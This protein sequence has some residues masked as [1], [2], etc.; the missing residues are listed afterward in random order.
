MKLNRQVEGIGPM[1]AKLMIIG[2]ALGADERIKGKPFIGWSGQFLQEMCERAGLSWNT[3]RIDNVVQYQ[4]D[5]NDFRGFYN[6]KGQREPTEELRQWWDDLYSRINIVKPK[7]I[8]AAG[9]QPLY[10]LIGH[11]GS[12]SWRGSVVQSTIGDHTC[13]VIPIVHPS[14]ARRCYNMTSSK[15]KDARQPWFHISVFDLMKA[16]KVSD[17]GWTPKIRTEKIFPTYIEVMEYLEELKSMPAETS[18]T[19]DIET[20]RREYVKCIGL[21]HRDDY[22]MCIPFVANTSGQS[23]YPLNQ[24]AEIWKGLDSVLNSHFVNGQTVGFDCSY[25][26]RDIGL[27]FTDNLYI[28]T[29]IL[30]SLLYPELKHDLGFLASMYTDMSYFKYLGRGNEAKTNVA[31]TYSYNC[32]DVMSTHEIA[33]AL[34]A[35]AIEANMW[36]Y[37]LT[38]RL[39]L[40]KWAIRQHRKGISIDESRRNEIIQR[41]Y[42]EDIKPKHDIFNEALKECGYP[43]GQLTKTYIDKFEGLSLE[44]NVDETFNVKSP[45]QVVNLLRSLGYNIK[46][47][48]EETLALIAN[49][50]VVARTILDLRSD[51]SLLSA[52]SRPTDGDNKFRTSINLHVTE[53][54][55]LSST[56]SHFGSGS[57]IQNVTRKARPLF[58]GDY[59]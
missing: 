30:H 14:Y 49:E 52:I 38:K 15:M 40:A 5:K 46:D 44:Y 12:T 25:L 20:L 27:W 9:D 39:P 45:Q 21:T 56:K 35:E 48:S 34:K 11:K 32:Q 47:S 13:F 54:T 24:E 33:M 22:A 28:D 1:D 23:Y 41:V 10:A 59:E 3:M 36:D 31:Q 57:N 37:Y 19:I 51:Y 26:D 2:E 53:T 7:V 8:I 58:T 43:L 55:R 18:I 50:S 42:Y 4:P 6:D 17:E 29:A 16:K